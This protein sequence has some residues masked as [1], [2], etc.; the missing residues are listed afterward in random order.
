MFERLKPVPIDPILGLM[1]SFREDSRHNK[2]DLG[3]GV[4]QDDSGQTPIMTSVKKAEFQLLEDENTKTYQG[5]TGD[6]DYNDR[7]SSLIF[8]EDN[9]I[10]KSGRFCTLQAPGGSGALRVG[11][12][13]IARTK[14]SPAIW[15]GTPTWA[16]HI[17]IMEKTGLKI[18]TY[19]YY[20]FETHAI[21]F[22]EMIEALKKIP[23]DDIVLLHGCCHNPTG[24][25]LS[26]DQWKQVCATAHRNG[27]IPFI[28]IAYQGLGNGLEKDAYGIR[29]LASQL[30]ELIVA[31]SCSKNFGLYRE[32]TG[33]VSFICND[34]DQTKIV[35]S[36]AMSSARSLYS[37]PPAHGALLVSSVLGDSKLREEWEIELESVRLR[38]QLMRD[39]LCEKLQGNQKGKDFSHI[40]HQKGMFS[41]LGISSEE[42]DTLRAKYGVYMVGSTRINLA[43]ININNIDYLS[44]CILKV[45]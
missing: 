41:F 31:S 30:P 42:V 1:N 26:S 23:K 33:A 6:S 25:D 24:A 36:H 3:V 29:E 10:L 17:P 45:I 44:E 8:G 13:V 7:L 15:V 12:E 19:P 22:D 43:G 34:S 14:S 35:L 21:C 5:M 38:I 39:L 11:A 18:N 37:M 32:R 20:D 9:P 27:F 28:D 16:N 4:Y 40:K 2:I